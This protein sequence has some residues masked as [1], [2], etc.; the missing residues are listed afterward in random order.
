[1]HPDIIIAAFA[2]LY[3]YA[4][5]VGRE[6]GVSNTL[7]RLSDLAELLSRSVAPN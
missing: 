2:G 4:E 1:V 7:L 6:R 3:G 5:A